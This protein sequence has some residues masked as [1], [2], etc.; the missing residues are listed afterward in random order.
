MPAEGIIFNS[1]GEEYDH[2]FQEIEEAISKAEED[3][4]ISNVANASSSDFSR[5]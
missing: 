4:L 3:I 1:S 2:V 5:L